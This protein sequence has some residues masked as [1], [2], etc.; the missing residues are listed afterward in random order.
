MR[1]LSCCLRATLAPAPAGAAAL[2]THSWLVFNTA[3]EAAPQTWQKDLSAT[4]PKPHIGSRAFC[5]KP[6][7]TGWQSAKM[8]QFLLLVFKKIGFFVSV[9]AAGHPRAA[10]CPAWDEVL[11]A[12]QGIPEVQLQLLLPPSPQGAG[13]R[14]SSKH[15]PD[16]C[17]SSKELQFWK[18]CLVLTV[19]DI[20]L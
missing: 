9:W 13:G 6:P 8:S 19:W 20:N 14:G 7:H 10:V 1:A 16:F 15:L 3:T 2:S 11:T 4:G 5:E 12:G 18:L 17:K